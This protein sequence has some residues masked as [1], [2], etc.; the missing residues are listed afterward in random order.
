MT[1]LTVQVSRFIALACLYPGNAA[2]AQSD[3]SS[4][5]AELR[6]E[7][8]RLAA[9]IDAL[10]QELKRPKTIGTSQEARRPVENQSVV[11]SEPGVAGSA[12]VGETSL[13]RTVEVV[14]PPAP[15]DRPVQGAGIGLQ[16]NA[17]NSGGQ[18]SVTVAQSLRAADVA[19]TQVNATTTAWSI[20]AAA[21]VAKSGDTAP[22]TLDSF[23]DSAT[24]KVRVSRLHLTTL[25]LL[26]S[27]EYTGLRD[28]AS[29]PATGHA[30][31]VRAGRAAGPGR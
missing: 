4:A 8:Q 1:G 25:N 16:L 14:L 19:P 20:T 31:P 28:A 17:R 29:S 11:A 5:V 13:T 18:V 9:R 15:S 12:P 3:M 24:L 10:E 21:P 26:T 22:A 23:A 27:P 2:S 7:N 30:R 6:Q